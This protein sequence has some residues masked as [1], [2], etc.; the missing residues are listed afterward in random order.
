MAP[1]QALDTVIYEEEEEEAQ[2]IDAITTE[3]PIILRRGLEITRKNLS[4]AHQR[5]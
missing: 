2:E 4:D 3:D 5:F 1:R